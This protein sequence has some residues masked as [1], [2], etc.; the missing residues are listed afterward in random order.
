MSE[1]DKQQPKKRGRKPKKQAVLL[2]NN[3]LKKNSEEEPLIAHLDLKTEDLQF[4]DSDDQ[5]D[6][7]F[8]KEDSDINKVEEINPNN[9]QLHGDTDALHC[10]NSNDSL[11]IDSTI[12]SKKLPLNIS[13]MKPYTSDNFEENYNKDFLTKEQY[14]DHIEQKIFNLKFQLHKLKKN[15]CIEIKKSNYS[16]NTK[17]WW[18]KNHFENYP[19]SLPE[20]YF[21]NKFQCYGHFCSFNCALS[22]NLDTNDNVWKK[23]SLLHL[24]Y[25]KTY[26]V[27]TKIIPAPHWT[28]L[29]EFGGSLS[30][31]EFRKNSIV[32]TDEYLMLKPPMDSRLNFFEKTYKPDNSIFS[33]TMYQKLL[34]DSD[35]LVIK[36]SKPLKSSNYSLDKTL[37]IKKK[38]RVKK[39]NE[40]AVYV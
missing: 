9:K 25:F 29:K 34:D 24:L 39:T 21:D 23:N 14:I 15:T 30:I 40:P 4:S 20:C 27:N 33:N 26:D 32:N 11:A 12:N 31:D 2:S 3:I 19:V 7:I 16:D 13:D 5:S 8:I 37:F 35:D 1:N 10:N 18:C 38:E 22:F 28:V 6:N 17:C 36:R